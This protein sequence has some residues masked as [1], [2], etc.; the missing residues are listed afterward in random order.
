MG[1][2]ECHTNQE[3]HEPDAIVVEVLTTSEHSNQSH[4]QNS[5]LSND[6]GSVSDLYENRAWVFIRLAIALLFLFFP[7]SFSYF[8][9]DNTVLEVHNLEKWSLGIKVRHGLTVWTVE[10]GEVCDIVI[11]SYDVE[12]IPATMTY[13]FKALSNKRGVWIRAIIRYNYTYEKDESG[14]SVIWYELVDRV[15]L[16]SK[17]IGEW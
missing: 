6:V 9:Q 14:K 1:A 4:P 8:S 17:T 10:E 16:E 15:V 11:E 12:K 13:S 7:S 2:N 3:E 5:M